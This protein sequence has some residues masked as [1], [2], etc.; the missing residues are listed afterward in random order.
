MLSHNI[1][2]SFQDSH[3]DLSKLNSMTTATSSQRIVPRRVLFSRKDLMYAG[4]MSRDRTS[5]IL[6]KGTATTLFNW[7]YS[8]I[9][10]Y[11]YA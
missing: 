7:T 4:P 9:V 3:L 11:Y 1:G 2:G 5:C 8:R 10:L 6:L